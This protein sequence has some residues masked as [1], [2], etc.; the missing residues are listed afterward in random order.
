MQLLQISNLGRHLAHV[1]DV[2]EQSTWNT[3]FACFVVDSAFLCEDES[4]QLLES[5][6]FSLA[7]DLSKDMIRKTVVFEEE[8]TDE[9]VFLVL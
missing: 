8:D 3:E 4:L 6:A 1:V 9:C 2:L 7:M 5:W